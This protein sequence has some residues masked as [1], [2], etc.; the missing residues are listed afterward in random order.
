MSVPLARRNLLYEKGKLVLSVAGVAA[1]LTLIVLLMGFRE[2]MYATLT[3]YVDNAGADLM[4]AQSGVKGLFSSNS[5]LPVAIHDD[6][7]SVSGAVE[8]GHIIVADVIF[9]QGSNKTPV[10]LVGYNI[11]TGVGGPWNVGEGRPVRADSEVLLDTWL[12]QQNGIAV[13]DEVEILGRTFTVVGLTRETASWMSPYIFVSQTTAEE[14]LQLRGVASFYLLRLPAGTDTTATAEAIEAQVAGVE[15]LTPAEIAAAD[16]EVLAAMMDT[17][18][19]VMLVIGAVIGI[20]VMGLTAYTAVA[21]RVREY[22]VLKAIGAS[23]GRLNRLV[24][25][26]TL[27]RAVLGFIL[28]TGLSYF[29]AELI[30]RLWPQFTIVIRPTAVAGT[31]LATLVMTVVAALLP[32]R[33]VAA[34]DPAV[35]FKA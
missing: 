20:A 35:V 12:A 27:Y 31:G 32:I 13:G 25:L 17:P 9:S 18:I 14:A 34:I 28:G 16:R 5:A 7:V 15:A 21:D 24:V 29:T 1:A 26:E 2:G 3:A 22:G 4:V 33:R 23:K 19:N 6:L 10:V 8:A 30:M 11:E